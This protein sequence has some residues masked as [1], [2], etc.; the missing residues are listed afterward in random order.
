LVLPHLLLSGGQDCNRLLPVTLWLL[1]G[2]A[3]A[4]LVAA[5]LAAIKQ[6]QPLLILH[7][8]MQLQSVLVVREYLTQMLVGMGQIQYLIPLHQ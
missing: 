4:G 1:V 3:V 6:V 8:H 2:L 5:V 7:R